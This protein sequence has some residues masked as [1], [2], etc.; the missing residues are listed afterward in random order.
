[1]KYN[2]LLNNFLELV[3]INLRSDFKS[4]S[5]PTTV[6]QTRIL[7]LLYKKLKDLNL[8]NVHFSDG[9][10]LFAKLENNLDI[11]NVSK[12]GFIAHVDT[13]DFNAENVCP[14]IHEKYQ[15]NK[16]TLNQNEEI[17]L[18][19]KE[20]PNLL[21]YKNHTLITTDGNTLLGADD[22]SGIAEILSMLEYFKDNKNIK[23]GDI[24]IAFG[25]D[26]EIGRGADKFNV[27]DFGADYAYTLDV[28]PVGH[29]QYETFNAAEAKI[30]IN[31]SSV[32]PS[33]AKGLLVS[34]IQLGIDFHNK[35]PSK[36]R[37]DLTS[38]REGFFF[39]TD[40]NANID[41]ANLSYI[42]RDFDENN[43]LDRK[44]KIKSVAKELNEKYGAKRVDIIIKDQYYNMAPIIKK[45]LSVVEFLEEA[46]KSENV[47]PI[48]E[49][50]R[51]GTD[52]SKITLKGLPTPNLTN[53]G[54]NAH[55]KFEFT[56]IEAM[57]KVTDIL[58]KCVINKVE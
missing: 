43:F 48:I 18:D 22:K 29:I 24:M 15:G 34:A 4:I 21:N 57:E 45:D 47:S 9:S 3:K 11:N 58:I 53:G 20:F 30:N 39:L 19:P 44:E 12:V 54:E 35:I 46:C 6:G 51:G 25:P 23:H 32:H 1:M 52:G 2:N 7:K 28:G 31:G 16:I 42:I 5:I 27:K 26:E 40:F 33:S 8:S 13:A 10:F 50:F 14:Q 49:P 55:G 41:S 36:D 17:V 56:S 37:P 38:G